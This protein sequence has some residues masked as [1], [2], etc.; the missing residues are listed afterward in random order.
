MYTS[1]NEPTLIHYI[2]KQTQ[3]F[4]GKSLLWV[5]YLFPFSTA[6]YVV[7]G[8]I[9][10]FYYRSLMMRI[11]PVDSR[12]EKVTS[13]GSL[14]NKWVIRWIGRD[15]L[16]H[17][18]TLWL[19]ILAP[20]NEPGSSKLLRHPCSQTFLIDILATGGVHSVIRSRMS[21]S[22]FVLWP[23]ESR[24]TD[25]TCLRPDLDLPKATE[26]GGREA[27]WLETEGFG[28]QIFMCMCWDWERRGRGEEDNLKGRKPQKKT[29]RNVTVWFTWI[30]K[31]PRKLGFF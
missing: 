14:I 1:I 22:I 20:L 25:Q 6:H 23:C 17:L 8:H 27:Q 26:D 19:P 5:H 9:W 29:S 31:K 28:D 18:E 2:N 3:T 10:A 24:P 11:E 16:A 15:W 4:E 13:K 21:L 7:Y 30:S 12:T